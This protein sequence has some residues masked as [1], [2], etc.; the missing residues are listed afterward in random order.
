MK[1]RPRRRPST[2]RDYRALSLARTAAGGDHRRGVSGR[3]SQI[4]SILS[5]D[6]AGVPSASEALVVP[7]V[8]RIPAFLRAGRHQLC[9]AH[10]RVPRQPF[11]SPD[12][13]ALP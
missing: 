9:S 13:F 5:V 6:E 10:I 2:R 12:S 8:R 11:H 3:V 7:A 4:T 1:P